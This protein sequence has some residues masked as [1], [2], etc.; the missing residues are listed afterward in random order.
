[1][2]I[3]GATLGK[4][5]NRGI[6]TLLAGVLGVG[7]H[8]LAALAG[9]KGEPVLL[10]LFVFLLGNIRFIWLSMCICAYIGI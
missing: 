9:D 5:L 2:H 7:A 8:H 10:C 6:A 1:M 3:A 4:G